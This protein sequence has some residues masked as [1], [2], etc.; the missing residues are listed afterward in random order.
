MGRFEENMGL[1]WLNIAVEYWALLGESKSLWRECRA[2]LREYRVLLSERSTTAS[3]PHRVQCVRTNLIKYRAVHRALLRECRALL[4][5][6]RALL[7][8]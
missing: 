2:L 1:I 5:E 3:S 6:Y 4:R 8:D 7:R